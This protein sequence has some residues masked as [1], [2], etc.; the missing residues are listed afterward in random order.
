MLK[1]MVL[2]F[3]LLVALLAFAS[4][5]LALSVPTYYVNTT[6]T[7]TETGSQSQPFSSLDKAI[8]AAQALS[9]GAYIRVWTDNVW[10]YWG[11][12]APVDPGTNGTLLAG[13][14]LFAV[15]AGVSAV[16]ILGGWFLLRRSRSL[17]RAV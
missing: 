8:A 16:L 17:P 4:P 12:V 10:V 6:Y 14:A 11:Y 1:K 15:M 9:T 7:G 5:A 2:L 3:V 13:P